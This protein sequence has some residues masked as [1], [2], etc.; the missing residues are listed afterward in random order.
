MKGVN[1]RFTTNIAFNRISFQEMPFCGF[2]TDLSA[3]LFC[4]FATDLSA[5]LFH[6]SLQK[7]QA[8]RV[9]EVLRFCIYPL[10]RLNFMTVKYKNTLHNHVII[11][12]QENLHRYQRYKVMSHYFLYGNHIQK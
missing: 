4:G 11:E 1:N 10:G 9:E 12:T 2:A 3:R 8:F 5:T 6:A 7:R